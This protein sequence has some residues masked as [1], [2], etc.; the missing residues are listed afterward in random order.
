MRL[1]AISNDQDDPTKAKDLLDKK[2]KD[3]SFVIVKENPN[4]VSIEV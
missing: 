1:R 4:N 2:A 3:E